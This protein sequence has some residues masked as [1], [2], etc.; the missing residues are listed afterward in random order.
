MRINYDLAK[1]ETSEV[2]YS[3]FFGYHIQFLQ[4]AVNSA[5]NLYYSWTVFREHHK[6][7]AA[8]IITFRASRRRREMYCDHA[9]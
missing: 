8:Y 3:L 2:P 9:R 7:A 5:V 4:T 1:N 6:A